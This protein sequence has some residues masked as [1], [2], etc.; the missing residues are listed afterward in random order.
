[1]QHRGREEPFGSPLPPNR[2]SVLIQV[3][4]VLGLTPK[5][6]AI[7]VIGLSEPIA[8]FTEDSLNSALY[9]FGF[10]FS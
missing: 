10:D 1:M 2:A 4:S 9:I 8:S 3:W 6:L 5:S 7:W